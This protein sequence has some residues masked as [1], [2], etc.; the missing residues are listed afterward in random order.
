MAGGADGHRA[1]ESMAGTPLFCRFLERIGFARLVESDRLPVDVDPLTWYAIGVSAFGMVVLQGYNLATG[2][3]LV[4]VENPLILSQPVLLIAAAAATGWLHGRYDRTID[5]SNLTERSDEPERFRGLV[6]D[7]LS[8][9]IIGAGFGFT[10]LN[11]F[12]LIG[13]PQLYEAGGPA[14]VLRFVVVAPLGQVPI[15]ATFLATYISAEA[16]FPRRIA[17]SD[18][19]LDYLDPEKLGGMRPIGELLKV[20]YYVIMVGLVVYAVALY[21]PFVFEGALAY[22]GL[23]RPGPLVNLA[24]TAVWGAA[25][26]TMAYG[27]YVLHRFMAARKRETLHRLDRRAREQIDR[28]WD[29]EQFDASNPPEEYQRYRQQVQHVTS[30]KEYPATF[31]MWT[32]IL[33][34]VMLPKAIQLA[35]SAI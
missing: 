3:P 9:A 16:L 6:P 21:G 7:R 1:V 19:A 33:V 14:R 34:G 5:R 31:T 32:Q 30:T 17:R 24:F 35:L 22:E 29:I 26:G 25:V 15:L 2:R 28:P 20:A 23:G 13:V 10:L 8:W 27:I 11:A 18:V 12:V 4:F